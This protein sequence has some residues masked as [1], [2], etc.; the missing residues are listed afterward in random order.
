[1]GL[2]AILHGAQAVFFDEVVD[3]DDEHFGLTTK[4]LREEKEKPGG[5]SWPFIVGA[6]SGF[7]RAISGLLSPTI[8]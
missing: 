7:L 5:L 1:L 8:V 4:T 2:F 3:F 6:L